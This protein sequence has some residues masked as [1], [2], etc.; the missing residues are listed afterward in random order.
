MAGKKSYFKLLMAGVV[1][2]VFKCYFT[3]FHRIKIKGLENI[4]KTFDKLIIIANHA[5]LLDGLIV[6]TYIKVPL[7]I[8]VNRG[9]AQE[10]LI[11]ALYAKRLHCSHRRHESLCSENS[12][13]GSQPGYGAYSFFPKGA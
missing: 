1:R 6:W 10:W 9:R 3:L 7:K 11:P 4:P 5:S 8:I 12:H 2:S 13:R